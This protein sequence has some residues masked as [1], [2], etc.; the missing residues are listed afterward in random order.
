MKQSTISLCAAPALAA[1]GLAVLA[2]G[3]PLAILA[4]APVA[5]AVPGTGTATMT[6][7]TAVEAGAIGTWDVVYTATQNFGAAGG[8]VRLTIPA[9][10]SAP[11][12][13]PGVGPGRVEVVASPSTALDSVRVDGQVITVFLGAL[14]GRFRE[15]DTVTLRYGAPPGT[16]VAQT[17]AEAG[18]TFLVESA[19]RITDGFQALAAGSPAVDVVPDEPAV[20]EIDPSHLTL[21]AGVWAPITIRIADRFGN[22]TAA[23][24]DQ[25]VALSSDDAGLA[26]RDGATAVTQVVIAAGADHRDLEASATDVKSAT[27]FRAVDA[28]GAVPDLDPGLAT[29]AVEPGAPATLVLDGTPLAVIAGADASVVV[30]VVDAYANIVTDYAGTIAFAATDPQATVPA[31]YTFQPVEGGAHTFAGEVTL[32]TA[33]DHTLSANEVGGNSAAGTSDSI[34][35][36]PAPAAALELTAP[37][38]MVAGEAFDVGVR[39]L[40]A[41]GN[42]ATGFDG[43]VHFATTDPHAAAQVPAD[44]TFVVADQ[45]EH[46]FAAGARLVTAGSS[47]LEVTE[48]TAPALSDQVTV[49]VSHGAPTAGAL[50]PSGAVGVNAGG[51]AVFTLAVED[52]YANPVAAEPVTFALA[53]PLDGTLG[54]APGEPFTTGTAAVQQGVTGADGGLAVLYTAPSGA[55]LTDTLVAWTSALGQGSVLPAVIDVVAAGGTRLVWSPQVAVV[56]TAGASR[57]LEVEVHDSFGNLDPSAATTLT[58]ESDSPSTLFSTGGGNWLAGPVSVALTGGML[59]VAVRDTLVGSPTLSAIDLGGTYTRADY[60]GWTIT[61]A[62]PRAL[63]AWQVSPDTL[64]ADGVSRTHVVGGPLTDAFGNVWSGALVDVAAP[65]GTID[66]VDRHSAPGVQLETDGFGNLAFDVLAGLMAGTHEIAGQSTSGTAVAS[67]P[68]VLAAPLGFG[69]PAAPVPATVSLGQSVAFAVD[70]QVTGDHQVEFETTTA[71]TFGDGSAAVTALLAAP[72]AAA[73]GVPTTL[74]FAAIDIGTTLPPA[75]YT[76]V[77][78]LRGTDQFDSTIDHTVALPPGSV[79]VVGLRV[80]SIVAPETVSRGQRGAVV[81]VTIDNLGATEVDLDTVDVEFSAPAYTIVS[82]QPPLST[83]LLGLQSVSYQLAVDV[84]P[85]ATLGVVQLVPRAAGSVGGVPVAVEAEALPTT[86]QVVE[87]AALQGVAGGLTPDGASRGQTVP[88]AVWVENT[89]GAGL[90]LEAPSTVLDFGGVFETALVSEAYVG[91]GATLLLEMQPVTVPAGQAPGRL[92]VAL[93]AVG[94]EQGAPYLVAVPLPDSLHVTEP[95]A[96]AVVQGSLAPQ[97]VSV[98]QRHPWVLE[99]ANAGGAAVQVE[100]ASVLDFGSGALQAQVSAPVVIAPQAQVAVGFDSLSVSNALGA[101]QH[102]VVFKAE[103][104]EHG[105]TSLVEV[106]VADP[107]NV[108]TPAAL[109]WPAAALQ[110]QRV[111]QG[112]AGVDLVLTLEN[113]GGAPLSV[114]LAGTALHVGQG[115]GAMVVPYAGA[116]VQVEPAGQVQLAWPSADV[117]A[118]LAN[119][120]HAPELVV[121]TAEHGVESVR[122]IAPPAPEWRVQSPA[123]PAYVAGSLVPDVVTPGEAWAFSVTVENRGEASLT[124]D[125]STTLVL[126]SVV[127]PIDLLASEPVAP[128]GSQATWTFQPVML[129]GAGASSTVAATMSYAGTDGNGAPVQGQLLVE[130]DDIT[131]LA[132]G[133]LQVVSTQTATV[134]PAHV[135]QGQ[136]LGVEVIVTNTGEEEAIGVEVELSGAALAQTKRFTGLHVA[137][138]DTLRLVDTVDAG[139]TVGAHVLQAQVVGGLGAVSGEAVGTVA[140]LDDTALVVVEVPVA[141]VPALQLTG[142][143]GAVDGVVSAG[144]VFHVE[145]V[146]EN[147]GGAGAVGAGLLRL[148]LPAGFGALGPTE[149]AFVVGQPLTVALTAPFDAGGPHPVAVQIVEPADDANTGDPAAVDVV[150]QSRSVEVVGAARLAVSAQF[151]APASVRAEGIAMPGQAL[152]VAASLDNLGFAALLGATEVVLVTDGRV[153]PAPGESGSRLMTAGQTMDFQVL[154]PAE[155]F[156]P[157]SVAVRIAAPATDENTGEPAAVGT[158]EATL[159]VSSGALPVAASSATVAPT[160]VQVAPGMQDVLGFGF[161]LRQT[162]SGQTPTQILLEALELEVAD[163]AGQPLVPATVLEAVT[164]ARADGT[165]LASWP[166]ASRAA[167]RGAATTTAALNSVLLTLVSPEP[168]ASSAAA[169]YTVRFDVAREPGADQIQLR[170][171]ESS[172]F[173]LREAAGGADV[174][175]TLAEPFT[176]VLYTVHRG[177]HNYPNPFAPPTETTRLAYVLDV[178]AACEVTVYT[179]FGDRVWRRQFAAGAPGGQA[180]LNEVV[181]DGRNGQGESVLTGVYLCRVEGAGLDARFKIAVRR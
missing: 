119:Q 51:T 39:A 27:P 147:T 63:A 107:L 169:S 108:T 4:L 139:T 163:A 46:V 142:P 168:L 156:A 80:S 85:L 76:P 129:E 106:P 87:A 13:A 26:F 159:A 21:T 135:N 25:L 44:Y 149:S 172:P 50:T 79:S 118:D 127:A 91:P 138:G 48:T 83:P 146:V 97:T 42:V 49:A 65:A 53:E 93:R 166:G 16:A 47:T 124:V 32:R 105:V 60:S 99:V 126:G 10:W 86:W 71:L 125:G 137:G 96:L 6:P 55:G 101:G 128:G 75:L 173:F 109:S 17:T 136:E 73:P 152:V 45:G 121:V 18:V 56:D 12:L 24:A 67:A 31:D 92:P 133:A 178:D 155:P 90:I 61:P 102:L 123:A 132:G 23:A 141:L 143:T 78:R 181:W 140:A 70:V 112:Q 116:P 134:N 103:L 171:V 68:W 57:P 30:T 131:V 144:Q 150:S 15:N 94:T 2:L 66:A 62:A 113:S 7:A 72:T 69:A 175:L 38:S 28:D 64:T 95:A 89:G 160:S 148:N 74:Q 164:L 29:Y 84:D 117:P 170:T 11:V 43:T 179:L 77:L 176:S 35:V 37:V 14:P 122:R 145:A 158:G 100:A 9:G 5:G 8:G 111:T 151:T 165:V 174:P 1:P 161:D 36:A 40:D 81:V 162:V 167:P 52:A 157:G 58:L 82:I 33:G 130:P 41:F 98:G 3:V 177:P 54:D 59:G 180:G 22:P 154:A 20:F 34:A 120:L 19:P 88:V 104:T 114:G 153:V 110:P 115:V